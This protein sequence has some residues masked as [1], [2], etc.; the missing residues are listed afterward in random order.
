MGLFFREVNEPTSGRV[1]GCGQSVFLEEENPKILTSVKL[2]RSIL[3][4][5]GEQWS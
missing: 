3:V 1:E 4:V 2:Y 5:L